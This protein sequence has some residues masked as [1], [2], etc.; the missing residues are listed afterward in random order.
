MGTLLD[1]HVFTA[2]PG[3]K[4]FDCDV[5]IGATDAHWMKQAGYDLAMR[6]VRRTT[7]H[8]HDLSTTEAEAILHAD[9]LLGVVQ[10]VAPD[11]WLPSALTG[12][13]YGNTAAKETEAVGIPP[14]VT[15]WCDLEGVSRQAHAEDVIGFL[16]NW[17]APVAAAGYVPGLYV[18]FSPGL[19]SQQLHDALKFSH[20]WGAYN[21]DIVPAV[22]KFQMKQSAY[23]PPDA[24]APHI[25][26]EYDVNTVKKDLLGGLPTFLGKP[27]WTPPTKV[28]K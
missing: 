2:P 24:R 11:G 17:F 19:T 12:T 16:N 28:K 4:G 8:P 1:G 6:Y 7:K 23:P 13:K 10:H 25:A 5:A 18:G 3:L 9:L 14:G 26:F 21:V 20:Y 22:R 15:V 27:G